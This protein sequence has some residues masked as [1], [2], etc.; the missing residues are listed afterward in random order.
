MPIHPRSGRAEH[1]RS[2]PYSA[3][4]NGVRAGNMHKREQLSDFVEE[5]INASVVIATGRARERVV[6]YFKSS[7]FEKWWARQG[8]NL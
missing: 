6:E 7:G 2:Q 8:L 1:P 3:R 4:P 5:K